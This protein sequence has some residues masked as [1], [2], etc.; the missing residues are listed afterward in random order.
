MFSS[1][2]KRR[3][4]GFALAILGIASLAAQEPVK[5]D[6]IFRSDRARIDAQLVMPAGDEPVVGAVVFAGGSGPGDVR[7]YVQDF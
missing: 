6:V 2:W 1:M 7:V 5:T 3:V 4:L